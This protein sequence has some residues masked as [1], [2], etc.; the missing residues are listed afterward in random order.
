MLFRSAVAFPLFVVLNYKAIFNNFKTLL[1]LTLIVIVVF[2]G[3][4]AYTDR[5]IT[6]RILSTFT[7]V[8]SDNYVKKIEARDKS[9]ILDVG[10]KI[11]KID[12][13]LVEADQWQLE[14]TLDGQPITPN[15]EDANGH[16][17]FSNPELNGVKNYMAQFE[18]TL[19]L[20]V[21]TLGTPWHFA[22]DQ[23][24]DLS[25]FNVF[26][27][28]DQIIE[29]DT[30]GFEGRERLGSARGYIWSRSLPLIREKWLFGYG[31]DTFPVVF[32]QQDY[33]GKYN[34]YGTTN[35]IVDKAHNIYIQLA[36]N[37]G[38]FG[39]MMYLVLILLAIIRG[40]QRMFKVKYSL[41]DLIQVTLT[42]SLFSYMVASMFNDS[43]VHVSPVFWVI[44]A[45]S[46]STYKTEGDLNGTETLRG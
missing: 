8:A 45:L 7:Q 34:A 46:L 12:V 18:G 15:P 2:V 9:V 33:V 25:Y 13:S 26:G 38:I 21:E 28:Y 24:G 6:N 23:R 1:I 4:E 11:F 43:T 17:T 3:F 39:L 36:L 35:M 14:Y 42:T 20:A 30:F 32:P 27:K 31:P 16:I 10:G 5:F 29:P 44:L 22:F 41:Q 40:V 37:S 19:L